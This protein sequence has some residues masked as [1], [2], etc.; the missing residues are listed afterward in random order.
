MGG[1]RE[2]RDLAGEREDPERVERTGSEAIEGG[3]ERVG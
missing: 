3:G 1:L 2:I